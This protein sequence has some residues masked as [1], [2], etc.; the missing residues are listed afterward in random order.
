[1]RTISLSV[2]VRSV[3]AVASDCVRTLLLTTVSLSGVPLVAGAAAGDLSTVDM[4][5]CVG[6]SSEV[7]R[8][9]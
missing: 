9:P 6:R 8:S 2:Y 7:R 3:T 1:M 5:V 4:S